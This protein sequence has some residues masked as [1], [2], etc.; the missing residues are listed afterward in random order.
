MPHPSWHIGALGILELWQRTKGQGI[1][2]AVLDSGLSN[3]PGM[4]EPRV[5]LFDER[6]QPTLRGDRRGH[7]TMV[8]SALG[9]N[10][11]D[12]EGV[13]PAAQLSC[14]NIYALEADPVAEHAALAIEAAL[15]MNVDL[16][17]AA[18]TMPNTPQVL[19]DALRRARAR[20]VPVLASAGNDANKF[21]SFPERVSI[22]DANPNNQ[23]SVLSVAASGRQR[24]LWPGRIGPWTTIAAPG[25]D[26]LIQGQHGPAMFNGTSAAAPV[27]AGVAALALAR[28]RARGQEVELRQHLATRFFQTGDPHPHVRI[29][30]P[31]ALLAQIG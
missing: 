15:A 31:R 18:F 23:F 8:A 22:S 28:A 13:A 26:I 4:A 17:C 5:R 16:I 3:I 1:H 11:P 7:G 27:A 21:G 20:N 29:L 14:F 25:L 2:V 9:C 19:D 30:N 12:L 24:Q 6:G 10:T